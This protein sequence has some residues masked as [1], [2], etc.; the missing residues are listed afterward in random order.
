MAKKIRNVRQNIFRIFRPLNGKVQRQEILFPQHFRIN[1]RHFDLFILHHDLPLHLAL[2]LFY[3]S[4]SFCAVQETPK[5]TN[6]SHGSFMICAFGNFKCRQQWRQ[7]NGLECAARCWA[8]C[9]VSSQ[10]SPIPDTRLQPFFNCPYLC[11][12]YFIAFCKEL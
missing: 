7:P 5:K 6:N 4:S 2:L 9:W 8:S 10:R 1:C 11:Q 3:F 12:V